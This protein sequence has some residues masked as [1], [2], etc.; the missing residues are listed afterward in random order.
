MGTLLL[1][2]AGSTTEEEEVKGTITIP[3]VAHDSEQD[4]YVVCSICPTS[5]LSS[6]R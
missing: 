4:E 5:R 1:T 3:E 2:Q 6:R